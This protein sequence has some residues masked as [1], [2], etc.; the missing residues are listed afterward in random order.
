MLYID[1]IFRNIYL[2]Y[3]Y[4]TYIHTIT[5]KAHSKVGLYLSETFFDTSIND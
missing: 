1:V 2:C 3:M 4:I 5:Y